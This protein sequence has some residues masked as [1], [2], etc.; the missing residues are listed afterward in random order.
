MIVV[1]NTTPLIGLASIKRFDLSYRLFGEVHIGKAVCDEIRKAETT[2]KTALQEVFTSSW[3]KRVMVS[4]RLWV[5]MDEKKGR[6]K[7]VQLGLSKTGTLG[8]LL[9]AKVVGLIPQIKPELIKLQE[10]GFSLSQAVID[11]VLQQPGE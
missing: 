9:K 10:H 2:K 7:P 5:I 11:M 6:Q 1:A 8:I 3:L 4:D